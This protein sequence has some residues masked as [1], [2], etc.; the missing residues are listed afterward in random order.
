MC[1][2][3]RA[4]RNSTGQHCQYRILKAACLWSTVTCHRFIRLLLVA[5]FVD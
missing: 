3:K 1:L 2:R 5:T 4:Q